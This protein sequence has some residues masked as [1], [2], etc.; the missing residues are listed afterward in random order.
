LK[1]PIFEG[2]IPADDFVKWIKHM[3]KT[4]GP[5]SKVTNIPGKRDLVFLFNPQDFE[6]V[7]RHEGQWPE[8]LLFDT[9]PYY[10]NVVRKDFFEG[11]G[12]ILV[13]YVKQ[14]FLLANIYKKAIHL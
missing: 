7:F 2:T 1:C 14:I 12:G 3:Q 8:R 6:V 4:Y 13:E 5:I 9:I 10:R 11:I